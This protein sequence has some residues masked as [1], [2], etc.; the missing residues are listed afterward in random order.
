MSDP[1]LPPLLGRKILVVED[2]YMIAAD[3]SFLVEEAGAE[4]AGPVGSVAEALS[5]IG[6]GGGELD[7]A[8]LD[9][10]L[11]GERAFPVAD[12]LTSLHVPFVFTTGYDAMLVPEPYSSV[13]R[14]EK[15]IDRELLIQALAHAHHG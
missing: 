4:V 12:A 5:L 7:A 11:G 6:T 8:I 1:T 3:L 2:E 10:N 15:P 9:I 14:M 13:R